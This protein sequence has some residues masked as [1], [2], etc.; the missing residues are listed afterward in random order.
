[1]QDQLLQTLRFLTTQHPSP[2]GLDLAVGRVQEWSHTVLSKNGSPSAS[3]NI[4]SPVH[5]PDIRLCAGI[6]SEWLAAPLQ[7][8]IPHHDGAEGTVGLRMCYLNLTGCH[9]SLY[10]AIVSIMDS[11]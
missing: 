1:M 7:C 8:I 9:L 5:A 11:H 10:P 6:R 3:V 2:S 4:N